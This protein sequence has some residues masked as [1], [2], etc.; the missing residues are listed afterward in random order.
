MGIRRSL[1]SLLGYGLIL[2]I[3]SGGFWHLQTQQRTLIDATLDLAMTQERLGQQLHLLHATHGTYAQEHSRLLTTQ[4]HL[5]ALQ[6]RTVAL[7]AA[8]L[9]LLDEYV[10]LV[11]QKAHERPEVPM[12]ASLRNR[13]T[14]PS[15]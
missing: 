14:V 12:P 5:L 10:W 2:L 15:R 3:L 4:E 8:I 13:L 9:T 7:H 6:Q 1:A 11:S